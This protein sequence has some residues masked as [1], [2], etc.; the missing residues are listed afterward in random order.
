YY[1]QASKIGLAHNDILGAARNYQN[2]N[3]IYATI[4]EIQK[5]ITTIDTAVVLYKKV[6][7]DKNICECYNI[8]GLRYHA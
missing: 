3:S 4:G 8:L 6:S 2:K 1:T 7:A 5:S